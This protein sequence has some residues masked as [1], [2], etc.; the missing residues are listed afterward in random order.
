MILGTIESLL[1]S[2]WFGVAMFAAGLLLADPIKASIK[3]L[4]N[5]G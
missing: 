3:R 4:F 5:R 1:G 2:I